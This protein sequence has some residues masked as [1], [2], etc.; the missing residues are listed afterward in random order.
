MR[1]TRLRAI[2]Q[3]YREAFDAFGPDDVAY[4]R[5]YIGGHETAT[6]GPR[7]RALEPMAVVRPIG[8]VKRRLHLGVWQNEFLREFL[9]G[10][11]SAAHLAEPGTDWVFPPDD[12]VEWLAE[13]L[14]HA[15]DLV[16]GWGGALSGLAL[17]PA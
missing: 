4:N 13:R 11:E 3:A 6:I 16:R 7:L 17:S 5:P 9:L 1:P 15:H 12:R 2:G 14:R 8:G 10:P